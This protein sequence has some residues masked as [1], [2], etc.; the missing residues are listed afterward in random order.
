M[1]PERLQAVC[2]LRLTC[3]QHQSEWIILRAE[4][5]NVLITA[6]DA[7]V[8]AVVVALLPDLRRPMYAW[9]RE[10]ALPA[11]HEVGTLLIRD[12]G[13][14]S[15]DQQRALLSWLNPPAVLGHIQVVSTTAFE[16]FSLVAQGVFLEALYYRLNTVRL[17]MLESEC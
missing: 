9:A 7:M 6:P 5:T 3:R 12:V 14:L 1:D 15:L 16:V 8:D 11:P 2:Q 4:R 10:G 13:R 17:D